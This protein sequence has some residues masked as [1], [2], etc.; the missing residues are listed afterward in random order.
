MSSVA[1]VSNHEVL[2]QEFCEGLDMLEK[3]KR[4]ILRKMNRS[5][6]ATN[7]NKYNLDGT[8]Q[9]GNKDKWN[10]SK[11][12]WKLLFELK[13]INRKL[14]AVRK[15]MHN[16]LANQI[17]EMGN[18]LFCEKMNYKGLQKTKF[19]KRMGYKAPSMFLSILDTKLTHQGK[20]IDY[21]NTWTAKASQYCP[22]SNTYVKKKL[23]QRFHITPDGVKIKRDCF[24][25]WLIKNINSAK[26]KINRKKCLSDFLSFYENYKRTELIL[27][28]LDKELISSIGL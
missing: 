9:A 18:T 16:K 15:I 2:I 6:M 20:K 10:R 8:I 13:E 24:S 17:L 12:Y 25:T 27:R 14:A 28:S 5:R 11:R 26:D 1:A 19:G 4:R 7:P 22:F 3:E 21:T 23:S